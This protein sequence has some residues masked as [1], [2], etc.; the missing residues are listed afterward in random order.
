MLFNSVEHC[1]IVVN[2]VLRALDPLRETTWLSSHRYRSHS[3]VNV[4][5]HNLEQTT[6]KSVL[7][8]SLWN[9]TRRLFDG[10][11]SSHYPT[12]I[13]A[14]RPY[15]VLLDCSQCN[16][17][18]DCY[19]AYFTQRVPKRMYLATSDVKLTALRRVSAAAKTAP[20]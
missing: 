1:D 18:M 16:A 2:K 7:H 15:F 5:N 11:A 20:L 4:P 19:Q 14:P 10:L 13:T 17:W 9:R 8:H 3:R 12:T 6:V